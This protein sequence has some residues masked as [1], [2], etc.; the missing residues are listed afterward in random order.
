MKYYLLV[1]IIGIISGCLILAVTGCSTVTMFHSLDYANYG[2]I[3]KA[4]KTP[5]DIESISTQYRYIKDQGDWDE[6]KL[7][8]YFVTDGGGDCDDY[9][10]FAYEELKKLGYETRMVVLIGDTRHAICWY[11]DGKKEYVFDNGLRWRIK[12]LWDYTLK[13]GFETWVYK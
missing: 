2:E 1:I 6:Y 7:P 13:S 3:N 12:D 11:K 8:E 9:A 5:S 4:I 10:R